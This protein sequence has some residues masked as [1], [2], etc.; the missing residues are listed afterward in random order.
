MIISSEDNEM[1][2]VRMLTPYEETLRI[3]VHDLLGQKL[4]ENK[5]EKSARVYEYQLD[6]SY[7]AA[8]VYLIRVGT[9]KVGKV[10]R[11]IVY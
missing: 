9:R 7:A 6:M 5:I 3:T 8:G 2:Q 4:V 11:I 10:Q 1:F